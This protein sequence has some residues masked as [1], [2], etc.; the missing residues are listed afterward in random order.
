[1]T[2]ILNKLWRLILNKLNVKRRNWKKLL[3]KKI[4][5]STQVNLS[6][7]QPGSWDRDNPIEINQ[8]KL[9]NS[10]FNQLKFW[11][12]K[13]KKSIKKKVKKHESIEINMLNPLSKL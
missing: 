13:W 3:N 2:I 12:I 9:W 10:I 1:M 8:K 7:L 5:E 4:H 6:N 11:R